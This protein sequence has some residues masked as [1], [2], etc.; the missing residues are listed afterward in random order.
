MT[1]KDYIKIAATLKE[2]Q[3]EINWR[4]PNMVGKFALMLKADNPRFDQEKFLQAV[5]KN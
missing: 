1:Q 3:A 4:I 2:I 5:Y